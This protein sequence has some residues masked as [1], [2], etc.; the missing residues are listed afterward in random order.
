MDMF[1]PAPPRPARGNVAGGMDEGKEIV[2]KLCRCAGVPGSEGILAG[3]E[4]WWAQTGLKGEGGPT[5]CNHV[6]RKLWAGRDSSLG[7]R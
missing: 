7:A 2:C 3:R 6:G 5:L 4:V 1:L